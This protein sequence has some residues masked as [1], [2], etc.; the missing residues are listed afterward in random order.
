MAADKAVTVTKNQLHYCVVCCMIVIIVK[1]KG[2][3]MS[4]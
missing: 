1:E 2:M 4:V 3:V